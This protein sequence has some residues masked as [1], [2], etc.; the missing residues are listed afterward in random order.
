VLFVAHWDHFGICGVPPAEEVICHGAVDNASGL[1][2]MTEVARRLARGP[3]LDRDVYFLAT[4]AE[5]LGLLGASAFAEDPPLPLKQIVAAFNMDSVAISPT[6]TPLA[7]VGKGMTPLD[8]Q[9]AAVARR[10]KRV[11]LDSDAANAYVRRQDIWALLQHDVPTV[12]VSS[13]FADI[14]RMEAF[15]EGPYHRPADNLKRPIE[16]G[17]A[18][19]D[20]AFHVALG[21]WF[22]D[23]RK[24][25]FSSR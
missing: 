1:A 12:M 15:F 6:G 22:G 25:P 7:I 13:A 23:V 3:R 2:A 20:V 17:G 4:T 10:E 19:E 16:L 5:E 21:R 24:V 11:L 9:I 14:A 8:P 18:A